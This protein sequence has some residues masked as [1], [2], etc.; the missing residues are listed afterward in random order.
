MIFAM[1]NGEKRS[2]S[3]KGERTTCAGCG[4]TLKAVIPQFKSAHWRHNNGDCDSWSEPE[5][6]WHLAWKR[7]FKPLYCEVFMR[8]A[9]SQEIHRADVLCPRR[10]GK[11]VVLELQNSSISEEERI[12]R[13]TF[14]S[15]DN[16]MFWLLNM[17]R[18][19]ALS[20]NFSQC[21]NFDETKK[22]EVGGHSF[23]KM[24]WFMRGTMLDKWK[25]SRAHVFLSYKQY[26][27]YLA[28]LAACGPLVA[29]QGKGD[30]A[31]A[32]LTVREFLKAVAGDEPSALNIPPSE[33][34]S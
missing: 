5:G 21:L 8:D 7:R 19:S 4:G 6:E 11:G 28:T 9:V 1:I 20:F 18:D 24:E 27:F 10:E 16:R 3:A 26:V 29:S 12:A 15:K 13:E 30:F 31:L 14:Y 25:Q 34:A 32:R 22:V 23:Y 33:K 17:N 2:P